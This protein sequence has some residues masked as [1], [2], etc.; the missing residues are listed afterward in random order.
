MK[1]LI[2][3]SSS[4]SRY[5]LP[6]RSRYS[7]QHLFSDTLS[8]CSSIHYENTEKHFVWNSTEH[9]VRLEKVIKKFLTYYGT[10]YHIAVF[11]RWGHWTLP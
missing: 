4:A 6:F 10:R 8:L 11:I 1:L 9:R 2:M 5:F 3:L 7:P